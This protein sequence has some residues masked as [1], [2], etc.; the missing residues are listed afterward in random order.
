M[1]TPQLQAEAVRLG[2]IAKPADPFEWLNEPIYEPPVAP[3]FKRT[4]RYSRAKLW[5]IALSILSIAMGV[6]IAVGV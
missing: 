5:C 4:M 1:T 6:L 3:T 2:I